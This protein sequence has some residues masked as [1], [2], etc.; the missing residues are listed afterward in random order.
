M[1]KTD[2]KSYWNK[3]SVQSV[4][5]SG[6]KKHY[7]CPSSSPTGCEKKKK[8]TEKTK[9]LRRKEMEVYRNKEK[10]CIRS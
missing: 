6:I 8:D 7:K 9:T 5:V 3:I 4:K 2:S 1:Y 10:L